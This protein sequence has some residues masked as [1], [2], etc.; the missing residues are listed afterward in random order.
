MT[1]LLD[2]RDINVGG[3]LGSTVKILRDNV[4]VGDSENITELVAAIQGK[5]VLLV[6]HGF[7]VDR[8]GGEVNLD[9][10]DLLLP[11]V[12]NRMMIG[13]LWPGDADWGFIKAAVYV[14]KDHDSR[15]S[16]DML[17]KFINLNFDGATSVSFASHS[18][19]ARVMLETILNL[20]RMV[21]QLILMAGAI[22]DNCLTKEYKDAA[23]RVD[24]ISVLASRKDTVL[25]RT[26]PIGNFLAGLI[27]RGHP[28]WHAAL[29][30]AGPAS[31]IPDRLDPVFMIPDSWQ[32]NHGSYLPDQPVTLPA[33][34]AVTGVLPSPATSD[35][36]ECACPTAPPLVPDPCD[37]AGV[38][39][40]W[41]PAWTAAYIASRL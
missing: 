14:F 12:A 41:K 23:A 26:F 40:P 8:A 33:N 25:S 21:H 4:Q 16:G 31:A 36:P 24:H 20:N 35:L 37:L 29:G 38:H 7:N 9:D 27:G 10:L 5:Q 15:R 6:T 30:H 18:L 32:F 19:G 22:D 17:A 3:G 2:L 1:Y 34:C 28:Y 39:S 13:V 11:S